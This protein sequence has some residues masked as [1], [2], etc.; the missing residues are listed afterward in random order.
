MVFC[1]FGEWRRSGCFLRLRGEVEAR[2]C[3]DEGGGGTVLVHKREEIGRSFLIR[4]CS[5]EW[6]VADGICMKRSVLFCLCILMSA[7]F[8]EC[9]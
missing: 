6:V 5:G 1:L 2:V 9:A 8:I 7:A 4:E 3:C